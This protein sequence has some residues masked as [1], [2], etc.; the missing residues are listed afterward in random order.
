M[1]AF[2]RDTALAS[3]EVP[4]ILPEYLFAAAYFDGDP[5]FDAN[6]ATASRYFNTVVHV[7]SVDECILAMLLT[8]MRFTDL[9]QGVKNNSVKGL[10]RELTVSA[11]NAFAKNYGRTPD[12][13][14]LATPNTAGN[15]K[16]YFA[17]TPVLTAVGQRVEADFFESNY[18]IQIHD[19]HTGDIKSAKLKSYGDC[20]G[21]YLSVDCYT[22][23][24]EGTLVK[25]FGRPLLHV[26]STIQF[27]QRYGHNI[28]TYGADQQII[29]AHIADK[30]A[31]ELY[32]A[33]LNVISERVEAYKHNHGGSRIERAGRYVKES[34]DFGILYALSRLAVQA[35]TRFTG[36]DIK[37]LFGELFYWSLV[38]NYFKPSLNN[39]GIT[40]WKDFSGMDPDLRFYRLLPIMSV[41]VIERP[42]AS[43]SNTLD[44]NRTVKIHGLYV[45]PGRD[46]V[47]GCI[48]F[49]YKTPKGQVKVTTISRFQAVTDGGYSYLHPHVDRALPSIIAE[50]ESEDSESNLIEETSPIAAAPI[51]SISPSA[52]GPSA[53]AQAPIHQPPVE[54]P[55]P[56]PPPVADPVP[57]AVDDPSALLIDRARERL[58]Y[59]KDAIINTTSKFRR[60]DAEDRYRQMVDSWGTRES[61]QRRRDQNSVAEA[62]SALSANIPG[63]PSRRE[64]NR[65]K[66]AFRIAISVESFYKHVSNYCEHLKDR[67][68]PPLSDF[69]SRFY[70]HA[71][72]VDHMDFSEGTILYSLEDRAYIVLDDHDADYA[73]IFVEEGYRAVRE[74]VPRKFHE[75]LV[76]PKWG[77]PSRTEYNHLCNDTR[78]MI[79]VPRDIAQEEIRAGAQVLRM[80]PVYEE[81]EKEGRTVH[82]V[83]LVVD[84]RHHLP[85]S[86][87][88]SSTPTREELFILLHVIAHK[89]WTYYCSDET[90]AFLNAP[91]QD[92][93][94]VFLN[95]DGDDSFYKA[96]NAVYGLKTA[97]RDYQDHTHRRMASLGFERLH[98]SS[99]IYVKFEDSEVVFALSLC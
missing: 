17:P 8:G 43:A 37:R 15:Y 30:S 16:G 7:S 4:E 93:K 50:Q 33:D 99:C 27:Y 45:G 83:R 11:L 80:I 71:Y 76:H 92:T 72:A 18:N 95:I 86:P 48:R 32:L 46:A 61:R 70:D 29:P 42:A 67:D 63:I 58:G 19:K 53:H 73:N 56:S 28:K 66:E 75:A 13:L 98:N 3:M 97:S 78:S 68:G 88:Y 90:R 2:G 84:G 31:V 52:P 6:S 55:T 44:I 65:Q 26:R 14:Q 36:K 57:P 51:P 60:R 1:A 20:I 79:V 35:L 69:E 64:R 25:D 89:G 91:M 10:P 77:E 81:K 59:I 9:Y 12:I 39:P 38:V 5:I 49:A 21:F 24:L 22:G 96:V 54:P 47:S 94:K 82:K 34:I 74:G 85:D 41:L 40:K 62:H 23:I 87:T